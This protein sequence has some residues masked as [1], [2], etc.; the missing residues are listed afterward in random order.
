MP[1]AEEEIGPLE[2]GDLILVF[3]E[4]E[5]ARPRDG[6][7]ASIHFEMVDRGTGCKAGGL[8]LRFA[9][10]EELVLYGGQIGYGV[11]FAFRGR[12]FA[13]RSVRLVLPAARLAGMEELWATC[14]PENVASR[15]TIE[16]AGGE[17]VEIVDIAETS[18]M[19]A[20]GRRRCC[21]YRFDLRKLD[22]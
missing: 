8:R 9:E 10:T 15:R 14:D 1:P 4:V 6:W 2:D 11:D 13:A 16:K 18:P 3:R 7:A 20:K 12:G 19:Y 5:P 17:F 21:R 22:P